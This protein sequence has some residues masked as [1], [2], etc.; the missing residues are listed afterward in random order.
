MIDIKTTEAFVTVLDYLA[1]KFGLVIDT[2]SKDLLPYMKEIGNK[3]VAY[4]ES[5]SG[6]WIIIGI[7]L[8]A[9]SLI[10]FFVGCFQQWDG[11][12]W[13]VLIIG[14]VIAACIIISNMYTYIGC[15]TFEEKIILD[16]VTEEVMPKITT[17]S[18]T[19][20]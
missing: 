6:M 1:E 8:A 12:H 10:I 4:K 19:R 9:L 5:I 18:T 17:N 14:G 2:T 11:F 16:Y 15:N 3:I 7:I 20:Y 13:A